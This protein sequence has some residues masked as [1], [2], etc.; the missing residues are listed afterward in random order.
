MPGID[1][2]E[3]LARFVTSSGWIRGDQTVKQDAFIPPP[4]A[5]LSVTRHIGLSESQIWGIGQGVVAAIQGRTLHGRADV[6]AVDV[7]M[8]KLQVVPDGEE[9]NP[10][11]AVIVG[12]PSDKPGQKILA[13]QLAAR[14]KFKRKP[15]Q[16]VIPPSSLLGE[17]P[18]PA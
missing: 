8:T 5:E 2:S 6:T 14:A 12:W 17:S 3:L 16:L 15:E 7:R 1:N 4:D 11:H 18:P 9:T 13:Q 10:N